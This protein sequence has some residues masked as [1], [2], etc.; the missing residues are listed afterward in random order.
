M[1]A[2]DFS[3]SAFEEIQHRQDSIHGPRGSSFISSHLTPSLLV[4][5]LPN[6]AYIVRRGG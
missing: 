1:D 5:R 3:V 2:R 6:S 4:D